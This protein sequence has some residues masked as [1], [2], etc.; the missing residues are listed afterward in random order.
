MPTVH[1]TRR[2]LLDID[3]I[4]RYSIETWGEPVAS[5]YLADLYAAATQLGEFPGLLQRRPDTSLRLKL[6]PVRR[7]VLICDVIGD[8]LFV[9]A[10]RH[11]AMDVP[12]RIEELEP[13]LV[14]ECALL[15]EQLEA[16]RDR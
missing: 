15:A 8:D 1:F 16:R 2:A 4:D 10:V 14:E 11:G 3:E 5:E 13:S 9:L 6:F 7:H 12:A